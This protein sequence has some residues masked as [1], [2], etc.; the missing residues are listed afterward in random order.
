[1]TTVQ[2]TKMPPVNSPLA[3]YADTVLA[4]ANESAK[5]ARA[6]SYAAKSFAHCS[7]TKTHATNQLKS[8]AA[9]AISA[10]AKASRAVAYLVTAAKAVEA[11]LKN[12]QQ[13]IDTHE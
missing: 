5:A 8:L 13:D 2:K 9:K 3:A 10:T 7:E 11:E 1:M 12:K 6:V 4:R